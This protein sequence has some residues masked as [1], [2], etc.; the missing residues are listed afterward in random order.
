MKKVISY[1]L[2]VLSKKLK[3]ALGLSRLPTTNCQLPTNFGFTLIETTV[4][5][6]AFA[7]IMV[8]MVVLLSNILSTSK[9]QSGL[10]S[11]QDQARRV[12]FGLV[13]Q[14]RNAQIGQNGAYP[15]EEAQDQQMVFFSDI[16]ADSE[17]ERVRYYIKNNSLFRGV[18]EYNGSGYP[19]STEFSVL[20]QNNLANSST[21]PVFYYY[22]DSYVG[23]STQNS[24]S[25]PVSVTTV[26]YIKINL[27]VFN[28]AGVY[29][30]NFF[31]VTAGGTVRNLK[32]NLGN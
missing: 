24:L 13:N 21:T 12:V 5:I 18:V 32:T 26:K 20:V 16:D 1:K 10:L 14:L 15:L 11:D 31:T 6:F 9:K 2:L 28:T 29:N 25:Q 30:S 17:V 23:S 7:I 4:A 3:K 27:Q 19:T 22:N 8:G